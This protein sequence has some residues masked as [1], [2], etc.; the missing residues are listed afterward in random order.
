MASAGLAATAVRALARCTTARLAGRAD[1]L[2]APLLA[3]PRY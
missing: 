2:F 1:V 3:A